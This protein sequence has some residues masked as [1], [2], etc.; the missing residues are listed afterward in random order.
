MASLPF[1]VQPR[2]K[3]II[4]RIGS[5]DSGILEVERKGYLTVSEKAFLQQ[6]L[7]DNDL[8]PSVLN[9]V[10]KIS[11]EF[12]I[13]TERAH[14]IAVNALSGSPD[15]DKLA[16]KV[17]AKFQEDIDNLTKKIFTV[18]SQKE[19]LRALCMLINR[20]DPDFEPETLKGIHPDIILGL[21]QLCVDEENKSTER[22]VGSQASDEFSSEISAVEALEKK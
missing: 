7:N 4:E 2:L 19:Y 1:V 3:P 17:I 13:T 12:K 18:E 22:L 10:R 8:A 16:P 5:E 20:V 21:S 11:S 6:T 14:Q 15:S 9:F